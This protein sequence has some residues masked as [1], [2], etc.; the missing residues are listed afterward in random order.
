MGTAPTATGYA[1]TYYEDY[2]LNSQHAGP[3]QV[4][5]LVTEGVFDRYPNLQ[6][7]LLESGFSWIPSL[8]WQYDKDWKSLWREVPWLKMRPSDYIRRHFRAT[9][10]PTNMPFDV[11]AQ[12]VAQMAKM[13][14]ASEMLV[15]SSDYPHDHGDDASDLLLE[16]IGPEGREAVLRTNARAL[17]H[18]DS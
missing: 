4:L 1:R 6:I 9:L 5:S 7:L 10:T 11:P 15:Y 17:Y 18:L 8:M 13:L 3:E 12:H 2:V 16:T 14:H